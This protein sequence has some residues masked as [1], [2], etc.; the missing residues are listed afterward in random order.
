MVSGFRPPDTAQLR[1]WSRFAKRP[2]RR[3]LRSDDGRSCSAFRRQSI[4][5]GVDRTI[6]LKLLYMTESAFGCSTEQLQAEHWSA[7]QG[8]GI[9][10]EE[11][12][13]N[14]DSAESNRLTLFHGIKRITTLIAIL[15]KAL[16]EELHAHSFS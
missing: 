10:G 5:V 13:L 7:L 2:P 15:G 4:V 12:Q 14:S 9:F 16:I 3:F 8:Q 6:L 1:R 11:R